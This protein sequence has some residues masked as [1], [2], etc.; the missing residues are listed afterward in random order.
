MFLL[1]TQNKNWKCFISPS[2]CLMRVKAALCVSVWLRKTLMLPQTT[3]ENGKHQQCNVALNSWLVSSFRLTS[4]KWLLLR[5]QHTHTHTP[6]YNY[7]VSLLITR[8]WMDFLK[9]AIQAETWDC[10][11]KTKFHCFC[12]NWIAIILGMGLWKMTICCFSQ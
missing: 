5:P 3:N 2:L 1:N 6:N 8:I 4:F 7:L 12:A 9:L 11:W 10:F